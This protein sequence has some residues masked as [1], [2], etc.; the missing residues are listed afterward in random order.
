MAREFGKRGVPQ[1]AAPAESEAA[2][3]GLFAGLSLP[4]I[5]PIQILYG[6]GFAFLGYI[7][8]N[9][10]ISTLLIPAPHYYKYV[11]LQPRLF[12]ELPD[13]TTKEIKRVA[14]ERP[15]E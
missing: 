2:A 8:C 6:A 5:E 9:I 15:T 4:P 12:D 14:K 10:V 13:G 1:S 3:S 7:L 11:I